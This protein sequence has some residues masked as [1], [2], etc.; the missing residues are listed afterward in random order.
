MIDDDID[1]P[2]DFDRPEPLIEEK[3]SLKEIWENNPALKLA[4]IVLGVAVLMGGYL[5]FF[6]KDDAIN[7]STVR[8]TDAATASQVPGKE[9]VD[10]AYRRALQQQNQKDADAAIKQGGSSVPLPIAVPKGG[11]LDVPAMPEKPKTDILAEWKKVADES[12]MKAAKEA[13][14]EEN[15]APAP[16]VV[17]MVQPIRPQAQVAKQ[18]DPNA[19]K[20]L[21][22]QMRII[23]AAQVPALPRTLAVTQEDSDYVAKRKQDEEAKKNQSLN[24]SGA[25]AGT[26]GTSA[27]AAAASKTASKTIVPAGTV[28]YGQ[29]INELNS[30]I[31]GPV[32]VQVLS[33]PF[34]GGRAI[35]HIEVKDEYM[36]IDFSRVVKDAVSYKVSAVALDEK[37]TLAGQATDVDHHYF[38]RVILPAAADFLTGY[39]SSVAQTEQTV[40]STSGVGT[41]TSNPKPSARENVFKGVETA[42]K[43]IGEMLSAQ[44]STP[45]TV[46][47]AKG[48]T[49]G[50]L[51]TDTVT[52]KD[53]E[54]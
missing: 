8:V 15:S 24:V 17:P 25:S 1:A 29:L 41:T 54:K 43:G 50:L 27:D 49:M 3:P 44:K 5:L 6:S 4:A 16:E 45:I 11:G 19:A 7:N 38:A 12:R 32:L 33:G 9:E 13:V 47:I 18:Q 51:F 20:R 2:E 36:V 52:T 34:A 48:T 39:A 22:E 14:E 26:V 30:D 35:G 46:K 37:T 42:S 40:E 10:P 31:Q 53:A 21:A 23:V 28:A